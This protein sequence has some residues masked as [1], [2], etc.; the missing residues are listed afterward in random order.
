MLNGAKLKESSLPSYTYTYISAE[1]YFVDVHIKMLKFNR[2]L[3]FQMY[4]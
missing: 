3:C 4:S 2:H 1:D